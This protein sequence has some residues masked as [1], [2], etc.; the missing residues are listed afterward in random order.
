[1]I[2]K[3]DIRK[4]D[5]LMA[6]WI[7]TNIDAHDFVPKEYWISNYELVK[8]MLPL[9]DIYVY[10]ENNIIK[11]FIGVVEQNYIAGLFVKK[12]YQREGI[13]YKLIEYCKSKYPYLILNVFT[14]NKN[15]VNFYHKNDFKVLD[16]CIHDE[17]NEMEY[18]MVFGEK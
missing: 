5:E 16:E 8:Q 1:M 10:E 11:G 13:G 14:K 7:E 6:I 17:T 12:E 4:L 18:T 2:K 3:F 15:A 9:S